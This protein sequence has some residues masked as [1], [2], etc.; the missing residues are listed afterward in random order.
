M[1]LNLSLIKDGTK[2]VEDFNRP[3]IQLNS[4][5][6]DSLPLPPGSNYVLTSSLQGIKSWTKN[7]EIGVTPDDAFRGDWG[8]IA[9]QHSQS[10]HDYFAKTGGTLTGDITLG[11]NALVYDASN[12]VSILNGNL[13]LNSTGFVYIDAL[14]IKLND[15]V[16]LQGNGANEARIQV[17]TNYLAITNAIASDGHIIISSDEGLIEFSNNLKTLELD[18][19]KVTVGTNVLDSTGL[20]ID[21][22]QVI[23]ALG[24]ISGANIDMTAD[25]ESAWMYVS[26]GTEINIPHTLGFLPKITQIYFSHNGTETQDKTIYTIPHVTSRYYYFSYY[27]YWYNTNYN[28]VW[29]VATWIESMDRNNYRLHMGRGGVYYRDDVRYSSGYVKVMMWK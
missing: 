3:L 16:L 25:Y 12:K 26:A 1:P 14:G 29:D 15:T 27:W 8:N 21:G 6:E 11:N 18:A 19:T 22:T 20:W 23:D 13:N 4:G 28:Y 17:N 7:L 24:S 10:S 9:Y 5:K 2:S